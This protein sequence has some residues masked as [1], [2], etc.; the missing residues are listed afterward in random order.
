MRF[1]SEVAPVVALPFTDEDAFFPLYA[2]YKKD[3][4]EK[5]RAVMNVYRQARDMVVHRED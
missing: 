3:K 5:V 4:E 1:L 2:I